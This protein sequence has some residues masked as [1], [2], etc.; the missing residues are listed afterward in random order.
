[1]D[2]N[3]PKV[4]PIPVQRLDKAVG[5][6]DSTGGGECDISCIV[7]CRETRVGCLETCRGME[8]SSGNFGDGVLSCAV[9]CL[10]IRVGSLE[11]ELEMKGSSTNKSGDGVLS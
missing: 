10:E 4:H 5:C 9:G 3:R 2:L 1:M 7:G 6:L 11:I 8:G